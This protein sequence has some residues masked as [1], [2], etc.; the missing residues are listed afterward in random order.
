[1]CRNHQEAED[2][3][4]LKCDNLNSQLDLMRTVLAVLNGDD[5]MTSH[6]LYLASISLPITFIAVESAE[7]GE[8]LTHGAEDESSEWVSAVHD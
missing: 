7:T 3:A 5:Q 1:M 4:K 8:L 6:V 2:A